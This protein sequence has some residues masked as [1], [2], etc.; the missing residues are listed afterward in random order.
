MISG[1]VYANAR[2]QLFMSFTPYTVISFENLNI[3]W[4]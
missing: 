2:M 4:L 3:I 1:Y